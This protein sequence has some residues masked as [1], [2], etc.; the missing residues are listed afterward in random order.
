MIRRLRLKTAEK[1]LEYKDKYDYRVVNDDLEVTLNTIRKILNLRAPAPY[2]I[3]LGVT[4][5]TLHQTRL[6]KYASSLMKQGN[7][8]TV[9]MTSNAQ[10]FVKS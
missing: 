8:V 1:E 6:L 2:R 7:H 5:S 9:I 4:G 10:R 3:V